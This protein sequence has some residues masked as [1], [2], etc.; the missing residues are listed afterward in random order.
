MWGSGV[1]CFIK[2]ASSPLLGRKLGATSKMETQVCP[3]NS[4]R[5]HAKREKEKVV[6]KRDGD[7]DRSRDTGER[8]RDEGRGDPG[9][10]RPAVGGWR[11]P[12]PAPCRP[13]SLQ[14][15][16]GTAGSPCPPTAS[17]LPSA[18]QGEWHLALPQAQACVTRFK[19]E[20]ARPSAWLSFGKSKAQIR[21]GPWSGRA[22]EWRPACWARSKPRPPATR[23]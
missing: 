22:G 20:T 8:Q 2:H 3:Q 14:G 1:T 13:R 4:S 9:K 6:R 19:A 10:S 7:R 23:L 11:S 12:A 18:Q 15:G 16:E 5:R 21:C 17:L